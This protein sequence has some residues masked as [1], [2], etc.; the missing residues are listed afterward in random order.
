LLIRLDPARHTNVAF[1]ANG[2]AK[3]YVIESTPALWREMLDLH[4]FGIPNVPAFDT[5]VAP[6]LFTLLCG[7]SVLK[8]DFSITGSFI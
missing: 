6:E 5:R 8:C 1:G 7:Q 2:V 4:T 3:I